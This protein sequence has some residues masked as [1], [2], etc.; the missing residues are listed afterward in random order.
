LRVRASQYHHL[1]ETHQFVE[2]ECLALR[3]A[4]QQLSVNTKWLEGQLQVNRPPLPN[5]LLI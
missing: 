2:A 3:D 1:L 4:K 5:L